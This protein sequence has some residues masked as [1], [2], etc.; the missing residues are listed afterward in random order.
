[1]TARRNFAQAEA[2]ATLSYPVLGGRT[3]GDDDACVA[4]LKFHFLFTVRITLADMK[5]SDDAFFVIFSPLFS[6]INPADKE[7]RTTEWPY[8]RQIEIL[9]R[10]LNK[11]PG[12]HAKLL[13]AFQIL[14]EHFYRPR[15][16]AM[17]KPADI[18]DAV[19]SS[20]SHDPIL[21]STKHGRLIHPTTVAIVV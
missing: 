7:S 20:A 2:H 12:V 9:Q 11:A 10:T 18:L 5:Q 3:L 17:I 15:K 19:L 4:H 13:K 1:M 14:W 16:S 21:A 6:V 8:L